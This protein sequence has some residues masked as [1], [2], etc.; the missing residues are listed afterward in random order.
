[1]YNIWFKF[2][3]YN[4]TGQ[5]DCVIIQH[6]LDDLHNK[7]QTKYNQRCVILLYTLHC[8]V[9][10]YMYIIALFYLVYHVL[11]SSNFQLHHFLF[12]LRLLLLCLL[13]TAA[14]AAA[15]TPLF[16]VGGHILAT[17]GSPTTST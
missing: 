11:S 13:L 14:A 6:G 15:A 16:F 12:F 5:Q 3:I 17:L 7:N 10:I 4:P 8:V 2:V 9:H 1:M